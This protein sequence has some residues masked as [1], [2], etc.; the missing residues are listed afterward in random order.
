MFSDH[1]AA[2]RRYALSLKVERVP[3]PH[4]EREN[5]RLAEIQSEEKSAKRWNMA[6]QTTNE[7]LVN[8]QGSD[9]TEIEGIPLVDTYVQAVWRG[10]IRSAKIIGKNRGN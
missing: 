4:A 8:R 1:Y 10:V 9:D 2:L 5:R 6:K 3:K 7:K